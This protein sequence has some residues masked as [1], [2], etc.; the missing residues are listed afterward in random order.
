MGELWTSGFACFV[1]LRCFCKRVSIPET[2]PTW[3]LNFRGPLN[4][5]DLFAVCKGIDETPNI[6]SEYFLYR[7][8]P[9]GLSL[10]E[11]KQTRQLKMPGKHRVLC[12]SPGIVWFCLRSAISITPG[13]FSDTIGICWGDTCSWDTRSSTRSFLK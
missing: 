11:N 1:F 5:G 6:Q 12:R 9:P 7:A 13:P 10:S 4:E 2:R 8:S 3:S